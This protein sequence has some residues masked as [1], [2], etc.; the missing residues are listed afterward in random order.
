VATGVSYN[1]LD[2][3][4]IDKFTG[5]GVYYGS[6]AVEAHAC[7]GQ[8][9][10][11]VGGGNSACQAALY[12]CNHASEVNILIRK[13]VLK[14]TAASYLVEQVLR[15]PNIKVFGNTEIKCVIGDQVLEKL[16]LVNNNTGEEQTYPA[17]A[18]FIYIGAK[19]STAWLPEQ[20]LRDERGFIV[21][22]RELEED[23]NFKKIWKADRLPYPS[24]ASIPGVFASGD[25]R[26]NALAGISSAVGEGALAIRYIRKYLQEN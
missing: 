14:Q 15:T 18:L 17:K 8:P 6:A 25:V 3:D 24:E 19:P 7:K 22:G 2:I 26:F 9:I 12:M 5:A 16:V 10:F 1:R 20:V 23:K 4:G 21:T 11:I 13:D